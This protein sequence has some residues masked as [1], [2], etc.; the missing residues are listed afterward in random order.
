MT[1]PDRRFSPVAG[2]LSWE[3][4][5]WFGCKQDRSVLNGAPIVAD[6]ISPTTTLLD[7]PRETRRLTGT[8]EGCA[9]GYCGAC[10]ILLQRHG[11][12]VEAVNSCLV[13]LGQIDG[14]AVTTVEG[15]AKA[16]GALTAVQGAMIDADA[17]QCGYCAPGFVMAIEALRRTGGAPDDATIHDALA[18]NLCRCTGYRPIADAVRRACATAV[19]DEGAAD[20]P[21]ANACHQSAGQTF[22]APPRSPNWRRCAPPMPSRRCS[23][24]APTSA[25][26]R[27]S[28]ASASR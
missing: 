12:A 9:E 16:G 13:L 4:L 18:G 2:L 20:L 25:C 23:P 7:W 10:T 28:G 3:L 14:S 6:R 19:E 22:H 27:A 15:M 8:K 1:I 21:A 11:A 17:S 5:G 24:A 26:W